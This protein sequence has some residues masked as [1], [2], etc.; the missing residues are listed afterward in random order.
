[1]INNLSCAIL[2]GGK[3]SRIKGYKAYLINNYN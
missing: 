2:A 1:M 3:S